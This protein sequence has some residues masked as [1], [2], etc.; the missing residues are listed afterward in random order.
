MHFELNYSQFKISDFESSAEEKMA[1]RFNEIQ[2]K[3]NNALGV[4]MGGIAHE[5][6]TPLSAIKASSEN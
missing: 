2:A 3:K 4:L 6:N 5:I 1:D